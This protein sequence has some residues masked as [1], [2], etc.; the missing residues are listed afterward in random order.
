MAPANGTVPLTS[1]CSSTPSAYRSV[2]GPTAPLIACSGAMYAGVPMGVP[3][4]VS[5]VVSVS[6]T[7]ATPRSRTTMVPSG[8]T[9]TL[10]GLRSRCTIGTACTA[11][12]T[13]HN[14]AATATAHGQG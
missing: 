11:D 1:S 4:W 9:I 10:R 12:S 2:R 6:S 8:R 3:V 14:C 7:E 5:R 13:A